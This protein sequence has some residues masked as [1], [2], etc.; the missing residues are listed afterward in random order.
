[1]DV[2][3]APGLTSLSAQRSGPGKDWS[4]RQR[5]PDEATEEE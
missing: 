4:E 3:G 1:M 2:W 5:R